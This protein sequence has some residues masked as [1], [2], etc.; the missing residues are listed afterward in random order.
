M[1]KPEDLLQL[2]P[3]DVGVKANA[4]DLKIAFSR[5]KLLKLVKAK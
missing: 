2:P 5:Q 3:R 1:S 4:H